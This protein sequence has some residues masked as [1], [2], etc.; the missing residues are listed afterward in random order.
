MQKLPGG[1]EVGPADGLV[2]RR[3]GLRALACA[4][5]IHDIS[6]ARY[7]ARDRAGIVTV[8]CADADWETR[9]LLGLI[10]HAETRTCALVEREVLWV[11]NGHCNTPIAGHARLEGNCLRIDAAVLKPRWRDDYRNIA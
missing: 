5:Y 7:A 9:R 3:A 4:A 10:D 1:G 6:G 2:M 11:L 8:E